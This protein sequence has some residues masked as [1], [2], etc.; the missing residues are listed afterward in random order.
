MKIKI[1]LFAL[2]FGSLQQNVFSQTY[3]VVATKS[4]IK[5]DG[6]SNL[7]DWT[8][9][10]KTGHTGKLTAIFG[11]GTL[12]DINQLEFELPAESLK[13]GK[14]G[15]DKNTYKAL[16]TEKHNRITFKLER[17]NSLTGQPGNYQLNMRGSLTIAG[18][19]K[20]VDLILNLKETANELRLQGNYKLKM[21]DF[22]IDPPKALMGTITTGNDVTISFDSTYKK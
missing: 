15:M 17:I 10:S 2:L 20:S 1:I 19:S 16:K 12:K 8:V 7:H 14:S 11:D 13:S 5:V 4:E 9:I 22:N 3:N 18:T 21:T 6:T